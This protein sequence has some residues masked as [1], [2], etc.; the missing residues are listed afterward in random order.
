VSKCKVMHVGRNNPKA[1]YEMR[2]TELSSTKEKKDL[3]VAITNTLKPATQCAKAA[4]T[5]LAV[6]GQISRITFITYMQGAYTVCYKC[7]SSE[8]YHSRPFFSLAG[9]LLF[10]ICFFHSLYFCKKI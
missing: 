1:G 7:S 3:G 8:H 2:G 6:L 10:P 4:K 5:A 9:A